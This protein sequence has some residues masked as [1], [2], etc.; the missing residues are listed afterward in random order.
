MVNCPFCKA[1]ETATRCQEYWNHVEMCKKNHILQFENGCLKIS[2]QQQEIDRAVVD[3][4]H[5]HQQRQKEKARKQT[6]EA[7]TSVQKMGM[8]VK[9][10]RDEKK[11]AQMAKIKQEKKIKE[12]HEQQEE[13][14]KR[15]EDK[16]VKFVVVQPSIFG[17]QN[18][19][20]PRPT[21]IN[22]YNTVNIFNYGTI[23]LTQKY[24]QTNFAKKV[25]EQ[26]STVDLKQIDTSDKFD[27]F[28]EF[29]QEQ[30]D[31]KLEKCIN[32]D[33]GANYKSYGYALLADAL[34]IV[35]NRLVE[36]DPKNEVVEMAKCAVEDC[37]KDIVDID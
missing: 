23:N 11:K 1:Y 7:L 18:P 8:E 24:P 26:A 36:I 10:L 30:D 6:Q 2:L 4:K 17:W 16:E 19:Q 31:K 25:I 20:P 15:L 3:L 9:T 34:A 35:H 12:L 13:M 21:I 37:K 28:L 27:K 29:L 5:Q 32:Y 33:F 14:E 22:N